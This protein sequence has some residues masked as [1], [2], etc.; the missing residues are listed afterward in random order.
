MAF[1]N[2]EHA[3]D[4]AN[5][6]LHQSEFLVSHNVH[7]L[8]FGV[9]FL[10]SSANA[11]TDDPRR[12]RTES[13]RLRKIASNLQNNHNDSNAGRTNRNKVFKVGLREE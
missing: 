10:R 5:P 13:A 1:L 9:R 2:S 8:G 6:T 11:C 7:N 3:V 12:R 4:A